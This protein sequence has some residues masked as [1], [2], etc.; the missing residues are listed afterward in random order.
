MDTSR[1]ALSEILRVIIPG[2]PPLPALISNP[3]YFDGS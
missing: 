1:I 2:V 3:V